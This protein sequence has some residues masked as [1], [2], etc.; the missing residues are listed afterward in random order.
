MIKLLKI[1]KE[2]EGI[3]NKEASIYANNV[4]DKLIPVQNKQL[5]VTGLKHIYYNYPANL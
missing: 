2:N 5:L 3:S 1:N 4:V